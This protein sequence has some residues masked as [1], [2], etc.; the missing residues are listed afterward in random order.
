MVLNPR[1]ERW[2]GFRSRRIDLDEDV[3]DILSIVGGSA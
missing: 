3:S 2:R 1:V